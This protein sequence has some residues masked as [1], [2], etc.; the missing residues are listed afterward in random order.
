MQRE[1]VDV[2][3]LVLLVVVDSLVDDDMHVETGVTSIAE[4]ARLQL[5]DLV[6]VPAHVLHNMPPRE[7]WRT[8]RSLDDINI[9]VVAGPHRLSISKGVSREPLKTTVRRHPVRRR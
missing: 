4:I 6:V 2:T 5:S 7:S 3:F 1:T 9:V 8:N